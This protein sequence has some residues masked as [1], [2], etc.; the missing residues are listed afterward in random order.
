MKITVAINANSVSDSCEYGASDDNCGSLDLAVD[1]DA[2]E[3]TILT[4]ES[5]TG[6]WAVVVDAARFL[7]S[8]RNNLIM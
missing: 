8:R 1:R 6:S 5:G 3:T 7:P 4:T 2:D